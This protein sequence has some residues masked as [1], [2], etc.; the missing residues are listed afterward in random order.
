MKFL[1]SMRLST[2][3]LLAICNLCIISLHAQSLE[4][5][6]IGAAGTWSGASWGT[7][8]ATTGEAVTNTATTSI[9]ILT[10]GFQQPSQSDVSVRGVSAAII[11]IDAFPVP[12]TDFI[13][14]VI[15]NGTCAM[16]FSVSIFDIAGRRLLLPCRD[17]SS[18][19]ETKLLFDLRSI[20]NGQYVVH[21]CNARGVQLKTI[22]F[23]KN[24]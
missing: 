7:L 22:K 21:V 1:M 13:N 6:V 23:T 3:V 17:L 20:A 18:S 11:T 5:Q 4:R 19:K 9:A 24:S 10:Q 2:L 8:S 12:A 16:P 14:V 15:D